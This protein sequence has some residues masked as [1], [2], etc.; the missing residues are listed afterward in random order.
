MR[1]DKRLYM[2]ATPRLYKSAAVVKAKE[3]DCVLC[4]MDDASI[5]GE[6]FFR[7]NFSYAVQHNLLTDYKVLV[8]TVSESD[9]PQEVKSLVEDVDRKEINADETAKFVGVI[10][11]LSK[12]LKGDDGRTVAADPGLMRR[13]VAF[14]QKIGADDVP[15]SS[16]NM[17]SV[18]PLI[19][20]KY[21]QNVPA[22]RRQQLVS[23]QTRHV[24]GSMD[25]SQRDELLYWLKEESAD[26]S[27]CRVLCNV[28]CLSEGV[29]V[30]ALDAVLFM[31]PRNSQV[32]VVQSVG[33]VM[34]N[35][36]RGQ[37]GEKKYGYIII[38][39][40]IPD[41]VTP[42]EALNDNERFKVVWEILNALRSHDD[43]FNAEVNSI[44]L[45]RNKAP[46]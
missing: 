3:N 10:N 13:A 45:N 41:R 29:D 39:I 1:A 44:E 40:V 28:R 30:P 11:G 24:D 15:N 23:V 34:R 9:I 36:R 21:N 35:F 32:D 22:D 19:S 7:V 42:E 17:A 12:L 8:L 31:S 4:S 14:C 26:P 27:E 43:N 6:E 2:T 5:Y 46:R 18:L 20:E 37:E 33:R 16:K 38:P 25:A